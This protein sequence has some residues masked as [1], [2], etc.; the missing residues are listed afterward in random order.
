[1]R[2][3]RSTT[4]PFSPHRESETSHGIVFDF[5]ADAAAECAGLKIVAREILTQIRLMSCQDTPCD[6]EDVSHSAV[7]YVR[8]KGQYLQW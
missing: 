7:T 8:P 2:C 6:V 4:M 3:L 5:E 1:M